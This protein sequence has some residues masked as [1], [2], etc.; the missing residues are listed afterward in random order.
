MLWL[1]LVQS[2]LADRPHSFKPF[3]KRGAPNIHYSFAKWH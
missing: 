1:D 2:R 3:C